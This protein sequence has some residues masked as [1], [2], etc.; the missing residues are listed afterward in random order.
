MLPVFPVARRKS[1]V[2]YCKCAFFNAAIGKTGSELSSYPRDFKAAPTE[3]SDDFLQSRYSSIAFA[4]MKCLTPTIIRGLQLILVL[5]TMS[6]CMYSADHQE[7]ADRLV[8]KLNQTLKHQTWGDLA[9]Y[10]D[11]TFLK[12]TSTEMVKKKWSAIIKKNGEITKFILRSRTKDPR[13]LGEYYF[14]SFTVLFA[15]G[16]AKETVTAFKGEQSNHLTIVGHVIKL[17]HGQ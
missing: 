8:S 1:G 7:E 4:S 6:A 12:T 17:E 15:H 14:Y 3:G 2:Y 11:P 5:S 13:I 16:A 10:Y 9:N